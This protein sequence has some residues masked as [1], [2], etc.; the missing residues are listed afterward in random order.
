MEIE[1]VETSSVLALSNSMKIL[2][3]CHEKIREITLP[4]KPSDPDTN[5][6]LGWVNNDD[7]E[8]GASMGAFVLSGIAAGLTAVMG[9]EGIALATGAIAITGM[10]NAISTI[11]ERSFAYRAQRLWLKLG[12]PARKLRAIEKE[13]ADFMA[14]YLRD[15]ETCKKKVQK[16]NKKTQPELKRINAQSKEFVFDFGMDGLISTRREVTSAHH[17]FVRLAKEIGA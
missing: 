7:R 5:L 17:S 9:Y 12:L 4:E 15:M 14:S 2:Q 13:Q 1:K 6:V 10:V 11:S 16:I 3:E 8:V